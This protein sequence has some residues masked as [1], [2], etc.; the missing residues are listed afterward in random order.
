MGVGSIIFRMGYELLLYSLCFL[1]CP[2]RMNSTVKSSMPSK[3]H[4]EGTSSP[5]FSLFPSPKLCLAPQQPHRHMRMYPTLQ[6]S[7]ILPL[8]VCLQK[9]PKWSSPDFGGAQRE[10]GPCTRGSPRGHPAGHQPPAAW[11]PWSRAG[12]V[13]SAPRCHIHPGHAPVAFSSLASSSS[14]SSTHPARWRP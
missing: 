8:F 9:A 4:F 10:P 2:I 12:Q 6:Q 1:Q 7:K 5:L 11:E 3:L 14:S 13:A